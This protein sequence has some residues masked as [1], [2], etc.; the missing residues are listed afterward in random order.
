MY[1]VSVGLIVCL[2]SS[3]FS[4]GEAGPCLVRPVLVCV[5]LAGFLSGLAGLTVAR[6]L[7][8]RLR[9]HTHA[10]EYLKLL[11]DAMPC[12]IFIRELGGAGVFS[13]LQPQPCGPV[14]ACS[15]GLDRPERP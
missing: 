7:L 12:P 4:A 6:V 14:R 5:A 10:V 8:R 13:L 9:R 2:A 1:R 15:G 3:G 11:S